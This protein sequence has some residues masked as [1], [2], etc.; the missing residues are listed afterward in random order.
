MRSRFAGVAALAPALFLLGVSSCEPFK[1]HAAAKPRDAAP[2]WICATPFSGDLV[3]VAHVPGEIGDL[4]VRAD[5]RMLLAVRRVHLPNVERDHGSPSDVLGLDLGSGS[6]TSFFTASAGLLTSPAWLADG[7]AFTVLW[8]RAREPTQWV[9]HAATPSGESVMLGDPTVA[10]LHRIAVA[11]DGVRFVGASITH[12]L[13]LGALGRPEVTLLEEGEDPTWSPDGQ[14]I[15]FGR[16]HDPGARFPWRKQRIL[17]QAASGGSVA[18]PVTGPTENA[19]CPAF[20]PDGRFLAFIS[21][22]PAADEDGGFWPSADLMLMAEGTG[23]RWK[24]IDGATRC[25][26]P[27]WSPDGSLYSACSSPGQEQVGIKSAVDLYRLRPTPIGAAPT[28]AA[29]VPTSP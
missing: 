24:L 8:F 17:V 13:V 11:R 28:V 26:C 5:G 21:F 3:K 18:T 25:G 22:G 23:E 20:S 12:H 16:P 27:A 9:R 2:C 6:V 7:S 4:S 1:P 29:P 14:R 10:Q 15:A 19:Q